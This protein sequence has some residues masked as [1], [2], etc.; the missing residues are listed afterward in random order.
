M[1]GLSRQC[2]IALV[3]ML[4]IFFAQSLFLPYGPHFFPLENKDFA[5]KQPEA[6]SVIPCTESIYWEQEGRREGFIT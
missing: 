1:P 3:A 2:C 5:V 6:H 4:A